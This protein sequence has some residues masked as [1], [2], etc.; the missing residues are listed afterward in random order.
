MKTPDQKNI[1]SKESVPSF[2]LI[3][4]NILLEKIRKLSENSNPALMLLFGRDRISCCD[5]GIIMQENQNIIGIATISPNGEGDTGQ[6][7]IVGLYVFP[8]YRR[9]GYGSQILQKTIERCTARGFARIRMDVMSMNIAEI[10]K[11]LPKDIQNKLDVHYYIS[12]AMD[13]F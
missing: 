10:I 12:N 1:V 11:K 3:S 7:T 2:E 4:R 5:E 13:N 6:P 8:K 9:M